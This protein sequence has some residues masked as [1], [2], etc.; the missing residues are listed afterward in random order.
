MSLWWWI[1]GACGAAY[2][3]KLS[4]FAVPAWIL[5]HPRVARIAACMTV[6]LLAS[7]VVV[8]TVADGQRLALDARLLALAAAVV[9][10]M[11]RAPFIVVV[12]VGAVA[13]AVGRLVGLA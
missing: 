13:A 2:A 11:L 8:N 6:G 1:L 3:I 9:A 5:E 12:L 7:L 10:L 4:G